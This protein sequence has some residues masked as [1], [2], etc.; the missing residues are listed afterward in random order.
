[1][2][3][4]NKQKLQTALKYGIALRVR[5]KIWY[6]ILLKNVIVYLLTF[7]ERLNIQISKNSC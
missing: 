2:Y 4:L 6:Y 3:F 5:C 7:A 1:M